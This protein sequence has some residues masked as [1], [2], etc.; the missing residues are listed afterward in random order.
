MAKGGIVSENAS[1]SCTLHNVVLREMEKAVVVRGGSVLLNDVVISGIQVG[2]QAGRSGVAVAKSTSVFYAKHF[3][4]DVDQGR[5]QWE[6][7]QLCNCAIGMR[8]TNTSSGDLRDL[9]FRSCSQGNI[10]IDVR[11]YPK[12]DRI[13]FFDSAAP[14]LTVLGGS[15][16]YVGKLVAG[17]NFR[18]ELTAVSG[19][20]S[21][22]QSLDED[23]DIAIKKIF[24]PKQGEKPR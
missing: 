16:P 23:P 9:T 12:L 19:R 2:I 6:G 10:V 20:L 8:F 11:S 13:T 1:L 24:S 17:E 14:G 22:T 5:A 15:H 3:G 21:T 7:G 18:G 4:V